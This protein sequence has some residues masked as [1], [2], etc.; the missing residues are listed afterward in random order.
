MKKLLLAVLF[1]AMSTTVMAADAKL[2]KFD[3]AITTDGRTVAQSSV[4]AQDGEVVPFEH[5]NTQTYLPLRIRGKDDEVKL[6]PN[7]IKTGFFVSFKP[8]IQPDGN[9]NANVLINVSD[10]VAMKHITSGDGL[11]ID[12]PEVSQ[13]HFE[14]KVTFTPDVPVTLHSGSYTIKV[15]AS[16]I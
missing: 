8:E 4:I 13:A 14:Q 2:I 12:M 16:S 7:T 5:V 10:L 15:S 1:S 9:I 6:K 11:T 3:V